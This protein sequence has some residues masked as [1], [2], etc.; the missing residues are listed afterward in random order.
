MSIT[1]MLPSYRQSL[2]YITG[3]IQQLEDMRDKAIAQHKWDKVSS[4]GNRLSALYDTKRY[5]IAVMREIEK[6]REDI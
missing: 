1:D 2:Q 3:R 4:L 6:H 5:M